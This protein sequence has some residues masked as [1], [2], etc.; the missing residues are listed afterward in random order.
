MEWKK[1]KEHKRERLLKICSGEEENWQ[2][3][4]TLGVW[5]RGERR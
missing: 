5:S 2:E 4:G 3:P 1:E